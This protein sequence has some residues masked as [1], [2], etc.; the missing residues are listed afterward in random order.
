MK[1][2]AFLML[3]IAIVSLCCISA[4]VDAQSAGHPGN[5]SPSR[6]ISHQMNQPPPP[7]I[8]DAVSQDR[9]DDVR[10][11]YLQAKQEAEQKAAARANARK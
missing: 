1:N 8:K 10:N 5:A 6:W 4:P 11:L 2:M 3:F 9:L 7:T